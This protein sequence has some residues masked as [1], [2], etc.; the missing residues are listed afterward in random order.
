MQAPDD[1]LLNRDGT[2]GREKVNFAM[3]STLV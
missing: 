3:I 2:L 1:E